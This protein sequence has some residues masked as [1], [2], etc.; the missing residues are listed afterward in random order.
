MDLEIKRLQ[1][2]AKVQNACI[3]SLEVSLNA[4]R[5]KMDEAMD[6]LERK[7]GKKRRCVGRFHN[8]RRK[9]ESRNRMRQQT[10]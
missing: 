7:R 1:S 4:S 5:K 6:L 10:C 2:E 8:M 9:K 3:T